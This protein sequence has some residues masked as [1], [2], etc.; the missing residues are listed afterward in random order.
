MFFWVRGV[1]SDS[2]I[3]GASTVNS[4]AAVLW[5][6]SSVITLLSIFKARSFVAT[7]PSWSFL[8]KMAFPIVL[9]ETLVESGA[10]TIARTSGKESI[11]TIFGSEAFY[12]SLIAPIWEE[13]G[14]LGLILVSPLYVLHD[15]VF[16]I[17][18]GSQSTHIFLLRLFYSLLL[19]G[20]I[21]KTKN[22]WNA[23]IIHLILNV[24]SFGIWVDFSFVYGWVMFS[25]GVSV[26]CYIIGK[27]WLGNHSEDSNPKLESITATK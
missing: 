7:K 20:V 6:S 13:L 15:L 14:R 5:L 1:A 26:F 3:L 8:R 2:Q 11:L 10:Q 16:V 12:V 21:I 27:V 23:V 22:F 25:I 4:F 19:S 9:A 24:W 17:S 18:H